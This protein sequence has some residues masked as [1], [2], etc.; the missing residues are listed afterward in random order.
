L[1]S[2]RFSIEDTHEFRGVLLRMEM[3]QLKVGIDASRRRFHIGDPRFLVELAIAE[4]RHSPIAAITA[5]G[6]FMRAPATYTMLDGVTYKEVRYHG[7]N[8]RW[9]DHEST[10]DFYSAKATMMSILQAA[11]EKTITPEAA[12]KELVKLNHRMQP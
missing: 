7:F 5:G 2:D 4:E 12:H 10:A 6:D 9:I 11:V 3:L 8:I 1:S